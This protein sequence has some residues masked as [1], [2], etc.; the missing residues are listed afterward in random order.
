ME[1]A[2]RDKSYSAILLICGVAFAA[3]TAGHAVVLAFGPATGYAHIAQA[4]TVELAFALGLASVAAMARTL[5]RWIRE[6]PDQPDWV[7]PTVFAIR[8]MSPVRVIAAVIGVQSAALFVGEA[9]EQHASGVTLGGVA[10]LYGSTLPI[11][12]LVY[13]AIAIAAGAILWLA[14]RALCEHVRQ[15]VV[16]VR[17][18]LAWLSRDVRPSAPKIDRFVFVSGSP[19]RKPL[20]HKLANRPPPASVRFA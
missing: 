6:S 15:A 3:M 1:N 7:L 13:L 17:A 14:A 19:R 8:S 11:A 18:A 2:N 20:A 10:G 12:P 5:I 9:L 16:F 4:P